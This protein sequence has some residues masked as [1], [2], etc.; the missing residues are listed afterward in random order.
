MLE[1]KGFRGRERQGQGA[2][3]AGAWVPG[4]NA[5]GE[6]RPLGVRRVPRLDDDGRDSSALVDKLLVEGSCLMARSPKSAK[7]GRRA[8]ARRGE[9]AATSRRRRWRASSGARRIT[10]PMPPKHYARARPLAEGETRER[11]EPRARADLERRAHHPHRRADE[12]ACRDR[13]MSWRRAARLARQGPAGLVRPRR[14]RAAALHPGEDPPE[15]DHRRPQAPQRREARGRDRRAR[16]VR[17]LQRHRAR[18]SAPSSTSTTST[19]RTA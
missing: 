19:G 2:D 13:Q 9:P 17:R 18:R 8:Q 1:V 15:G 3:D 16:P 12:R 7:A 5:L 14:Q 10:S 11:E 6:L 4:V